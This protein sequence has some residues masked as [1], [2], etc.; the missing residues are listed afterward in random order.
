MWLLLLFVILA[1]CKN[2]LGDSVLFNETL[3][4]KMK[5][6]FENTSRCD[7]NRCIRK[8]C[9]ASEAMVDSKCR[10]SLDTKFDVAFY[11]I[12]KLQHFNNT[13]T[14]VVLPDFSCPNS[15]FIKIMLE[16][17][18]FVQNNGS[19]YG[20]DMR[21]GDQFKMYNPDEYCL[22]N[23]LGNEQNHLSTRDLKLFFCVEVTEDEEEALKKNV[24]G[25]LLYK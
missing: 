24:I 10:S 12:D 6:I 21:T 3:N 4:D 1:H 23:L 14:V 15:N 16:G 5:I 19:V 8:C 2:H 9:G 17:Q 13:Y 22:E 18:F 11:N 20:L 7:F 25:N